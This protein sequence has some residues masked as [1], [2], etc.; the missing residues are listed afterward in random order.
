M[1]RVSVRLPEL[2][3]RALR[4]VAQ[5]AGVSMNSIVTSAIGEKIAALKTIDLLKERASHGSRR[6]FGAVLAK[7]PDTP[8][9]CGDAIA[10]KT[11]QRGASPT[12]TH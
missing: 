5:Q 10:P 12:G 4:E 9:G 2:L 3:H 6:A 11:S 7:V 8:P 1:S